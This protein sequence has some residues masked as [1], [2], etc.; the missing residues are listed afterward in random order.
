[1]T[2]FA[3]IVN[4]IWLVLVLVG[5]EPLHSSVRRAEVTDSRHLYSQKPR[6]SEEWSSALAAD[7]QLVH[8]DREHGNVLGYEQST[9]KVFAQH[10]P[11]TPDGQQE[12]VQL[13]EA[14]MLGMPRGLMSGSQTRACEV[15]AVSPS[16]NEVYWREAGNA[17]EA[18]PLLHKDPP[19]HFTWQIYSPSISGSREVLL[20]SNA[21]TGLSCSCQWAAS[22]GVHRAVRG[23]SRSLRCQAARQAVH[24]VEHNGPEDELRHQ[25]QGPAAL[26]PWLRRQATKFCINLQAQ[27]WDKTLLFVPSADLVGVQGNAASCWA[28]ASK[29]LG[30]LHLPDS[31]AAGPQRVR[32]PRAQVLSDMKQGTQSLTLIQGLVAAVGLHIESELTASALYM[33]RNLTLAARLYTPPGTTHSAKSF[34]LKRQLQHAVRIINRTQEKMVPLPLTLPRVCDADTALVPHHH[35]LLQLLS[36]SSA[37][38]TPESANTTLVARSFG[39]MAQQV[40]KCVIGSLLSFHEYNHCMKQHLVESMQVVESLAKL[41]HLQRLLAFSS[42]QP[43]GLSPMDRADDMVAAAVKAIEKAVELAHGVTQTLSLQPKHRNPGND[44]HHTTHTDRLEWWEYH[45]RTRSWCCSHSIEHYIL[46]VSLDEPCTEEHI[47]ALWQVY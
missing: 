17:D 39:H 13:G 20:S 44:H 3:R 8:Y 9:G 15:L 41:K 23:A 14:V 31:L 36:T 22:I 42:A 40:L 11:Y 10:S 4:S 28:R 12:A 6:A 7:L 5:A 26:R 37:T 34:N 38:L 33:K 1:M 35:L 21:D 45:R 2:V 29:Y 16:N 32:L 18:L 24:D 47:R 19:W 46:N 30:K 27:M 43:L 25:T